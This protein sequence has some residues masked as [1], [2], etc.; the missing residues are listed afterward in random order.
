MSRK[1]IEELQREERVIVAWIRDVSAEK[2]ARL[3]QIR[4]E[5]RAL[6]GVKSPKAAKP[7]NAVGA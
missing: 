2:Q 6:C 1:R 5:L 4:A 3:I 7:K